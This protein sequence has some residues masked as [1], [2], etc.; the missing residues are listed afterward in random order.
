M[1]KKSFGLSLLLVL[2]PPAFGKDVKEIAWQDG[3]VVAIAH[4]TIDNP[5]APLPARVRMLAAT[6]YTIEVPTGIYEVSEIAQSKM[7]KP[8]K[9]KPD[10]VGKGPVRFFLKKEI[11]LF[12]FTE[13]CMDQAI[14]LGSDGKQYAMRLRKFTPKGN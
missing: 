5:T 13:R 12:C 10:R 7:F 14:I 9:F 3:E 11:G 2:L 6:T 8:A 4:E 1:F